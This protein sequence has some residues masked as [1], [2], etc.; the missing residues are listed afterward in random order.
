MKGN[1]KEENKLMPFA[2]ANWRNVQ[3]LG[4]IMILAAV[5][6]LLLLIMVPS[7]PILVIVVFIVILLPSG[8]QILYARL[9][10]KQFRNIVLRIQMKKVHFDILRLTMRFLYGE[11]IFFILYHGLGSPYAFWAIHTH[12]VSRSES[13]PDHYQVWTSISWPSPIYENPYN[14]GRYLRRRGTTG[15]L[16]GN[17]VQP[18]PPDDPL[19][20]DLKKYR[21]FNNI[22]YT[23]SLLCGSC[24]SRRITYTCCFTKKRCYNRRPCPDDK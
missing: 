14:L 24:Q 3:I 7:L 10:G 6:G 17:W 23:F 16:L 9:V 1:L 5:G 21:S 19:S 18:E 8:M 12:N 2:I 20:D 4:I 15:T 22:P 11:R 13:P